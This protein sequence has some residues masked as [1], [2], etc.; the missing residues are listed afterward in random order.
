MKVLITGPFEGPAGFGE[1][2]VGELLRVG[3]QV[4]TLNREDSEARHRAEPWNGFI[5]QVWS[6]SWCSAALDHALRHVDVVIHC[7]ESGPPRSES[8]PEEAR[9]RNVEVT[10]ELIAACL[11]RP[12]PT[13]WILVSSIAV[14]GATQELPPPRRATDP[15]A[16]ISHYAKQRLECEELVVNSGMDCC[17]LRLAPMLPPALELRDGASLRGFFANALEN[18]VELVHP[19]DAAQAV[20]RALTCDEVWGKALL[21]GGG[22]ACQVRKRDVNRALFRALGLVEFPDAAFGD[23]EDENDWLD[24][25]E[26]EELLGYQEMSADD[27]FADWQEQAAKTR[28]RIKWVRPLYQHFLQRHSRMR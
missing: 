28:T 5:G 18:R 1:A 19:K 13:R 4:G 15:V 21:V 14:S 10:R 11:R 20:A 17:V 8:V 23:E 22:K 2:L 3:V 26:S 24:T 7:A 27:L 12:E 6:Q 16:P 25:Q 9:T